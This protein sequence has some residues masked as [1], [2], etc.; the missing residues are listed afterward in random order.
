MKNN[1]NIVIIGYNYNKYSSN[2]IISPS[3]C[4]LHFFK[5]QYYEFQTSS[6]FSLEYIF[7]IGGGATQINRQ[8]F[9]CSRRKTTV[10]Y[11]KNYRSLAHQN[12]KGILYPCS[13]STYFENSQER[14][15]NPTKPKKVY[16][17]V[18]FWVGMFVCFFWNERVKQGFQSQCVI[19]EE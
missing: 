9:I 10:K 11:R 19:N 6:I 13:I 7:L 8:I 16:L 18:L 14:I 4:K 3:S 2:T 17:Q 12:D 5:F 15:N 1:N